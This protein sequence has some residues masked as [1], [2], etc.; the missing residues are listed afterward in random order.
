MA[1]YDLDRFRDLTFEKRL[2]EAAAV[3]E[4]RAEALRRDDVA[5]MRFAIEWIKGGLLGTNEAKGQGRP[6]LGRH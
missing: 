1:C 5:L 2:W 4:D 6:G 3:R